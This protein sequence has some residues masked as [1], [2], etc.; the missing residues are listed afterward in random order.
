MQT[1]KLI[2]KSAAEMLKMLKVATD[3]KPRT[4]RVLLHNAMTLCGKKMIKFLPNIHKSV[5]SRNMINEH[6]KCAT[7]FI[8]SQKSR[9]F[10]CKYLNKINNMEGEFTC[11]VWERILQFL[12]CK[13]ANLH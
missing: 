13:I 8:S 7:I 12:S 3:D 11:F 4:A 5:E 2:Q 9:N 10:S 6:G 1:L